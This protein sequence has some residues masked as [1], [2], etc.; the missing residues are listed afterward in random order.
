MVVNNT[1]TCYWTTPTSCYSSTPIF[2]YPM[3]NNFNGYSYD[4]SSPWQYSI[5][6]NAA[7]P[8]QPTN[9]NNYGYC[10]QQQSTLWPTQNSRMMSNN[11]ISNNVNNWYSDN[12][13]PQ[14]LDNGSGKDTFVFSSI[15]D[16]PYD[17]PD[18]IMDFETGIDLI[19]LSAIRLDSYIN[20]NP[21]LYFVDYFT[22]QVG[23][24]MLTYNEESNLSRLF[25][26]GD[27]DAIPDFELHILGVVEQSDLILA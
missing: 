18:K 4:Y 12:K 20:S 26:D 27:G 10:N 24:M 2:Y 3:M 8:N 22:K 15:K 11:Y 13:K 23:D 6:Y 1:N 5:T 9:C 25:I 21:K 14:K 7:L 19:D 17:N 16:S